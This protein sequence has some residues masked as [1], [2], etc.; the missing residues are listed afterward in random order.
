M[1]DRRTDRLSD[2]SLISLVGN[3]ITC[4]SV[5]FTLFVVEVNK[6]GRTLNMFVASMDISFKLNTARKFDS[7]V[8]DTT[9]KTNL[10]LKSWVWIIMNLF[11]INHVTKTQCITVESEKNACSFSPFGA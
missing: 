3:I 2:S 8:Q 9:S 5:S 1:T 4:L 7:T 6:K 10:S 11:L